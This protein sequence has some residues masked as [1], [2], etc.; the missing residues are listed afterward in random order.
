M[1]R[2]GGG[3][4]AA[5]ATSIALTF[6]YQGQRC[7]ERIQLKPTPANLKRVEQHKAAIEHAIA[8]GTFD[9]AA[10]FP[11]SKN[12]AKFKP[13]VDLTPAKTFLTEWLERERKHVKASTWDGYR[14]IVTGPLARMFD[15][16]RLG[17]I[18]RD[19]LTEKLS[20]MEVSNKRLLNIQSCLRVALDDAVT[21]K[22]LTN[23]PLHGW[24]YRHREAANTNP[25]DDDEIDPFDAEEQAAIL[26]VLHPQVRNLYQF[27]FWTGLRTS[28]L[29][30]LEWRDIDW[31]NQRIMVRRT[32]TRAA[33]HVEGTKTKAGK[34]LV[35]L[36]RPAVQ[37]LVAQ[38]QHTFMLNAQVFHDP[39]YD[40]PFVGDQEL[41]EKFWRPALRKAGVRYRRPYQTRHT[42]ASMMLS[43]G[44]HPMWVAQQ[45]GHTDWSMI[46]RVYGNWMD[47]ADRDAGSKAEAL[48]GKQEAGQNVNDSLMATSSLQP[49]KT[50]G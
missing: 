28:E 30:A 10:T 6:Q 4:R 20:A 35:K 19:L 46:A 3:V 33:E 21:R 9:Y 8:L 41:R 42:F 12:A 15:G 22:L 17:G 2:D 47:E 43:A 16:L 27:A 23:N 36:L 11:N 37:A 24:A 18:T 13:P 1:G 5:S 29:V 7:R 50:K 38:K 40:R 14:K 49:A 31:V 32:L 45:M 39:R 26:A 25:D 44:E 48:F 34:R